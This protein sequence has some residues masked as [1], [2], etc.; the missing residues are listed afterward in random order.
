MRSAAQLTPRPFAAALSNIGNMRDLTAQRRW[1]YQKLF[2]SPLTLMSELT[3]EI[4]I[5]IFELVLATTLVRDEVRLVRWR[6]E[7][8]VSVNRLIRTVCRQV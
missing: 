5:F 3:I 1:Q 4:T 2:L 6:W 8:E 7:Y